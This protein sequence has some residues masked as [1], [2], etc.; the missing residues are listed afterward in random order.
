M[1]WNK[2]VFKKNKLK[3]IFYG[4]ILFIYIYMSE[5]VGG[6]KVPSR[7]GRAA[8]VGSLLG[9]QYGSPHTGTQADTTMRACIHEWV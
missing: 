8:H 5:C 1:V 4:N 2:Y 7:M 3:H 9:S 6:E